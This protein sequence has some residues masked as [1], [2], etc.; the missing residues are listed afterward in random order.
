MILWVNREK[1]NLKTAQTMDR[2][3]ENYDKLLE[4]TK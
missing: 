4:L 1:R 2:I 3:I